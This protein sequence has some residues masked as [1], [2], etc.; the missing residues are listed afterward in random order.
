V[1]VSG[2]RV[3]A[4]PDTVAAGASLTVTWTAPGASNTNPAAVYNVSG[5][6]GTFAMPAPHTAG[7]YRSAIYWA[8]A[9]GLPRPWG[10]RLRCSDGSTGTD[11]DRYSGALIQIVAATLGLLLFAPVLLARFS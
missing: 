1:G 8:E 4:S 5:S 9:V 7:Q 10:R 11:C 6:S 2:F 3:N